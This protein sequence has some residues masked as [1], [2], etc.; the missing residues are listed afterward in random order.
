VAIKPLELYNQAWTKDNKKAMSPNVVWLIA[1]FNKMASWVATEILSCHSSL[2]RR[3]QTLKHFIAI[4]Y[5]SLERMW[6]LT[7][8][9]VVLLPT[10]L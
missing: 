2:K 3:T 5:V 1:N 6:Y 8:P 10:R 7:I 4:G 9:S